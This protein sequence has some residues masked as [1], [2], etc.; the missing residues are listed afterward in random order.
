MTPKAFAQTVRR[1]LSSLK[2]AQSAVIWSA[3]PHCTAPIPCNY[4]RNSS[5][6]L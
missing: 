6:Y 1:H 2:A 3:M 4:W 5:N